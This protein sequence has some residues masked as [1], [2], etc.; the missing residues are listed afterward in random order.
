MNLS[1]NVADVLCIRFFY[2]PS[3]VP[4]LWNSV[5]FSLVLVSV[6]THLNYCFEIVKIGFVSLKQSDANA[7]CI[8]SVYQPC[9]APL[10]LS[11]E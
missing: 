5:D 10:L 8:R 2:Q 1:S 6:L 9:V 3:F 7:L 11:T 4:F